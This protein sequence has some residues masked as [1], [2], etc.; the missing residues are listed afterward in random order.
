MWI[1]ALLEADVLAER[2]QTIAYS[3]IGP[4][5]THSIYRTGTIGRAKD[6]LERTARL[7]DQELQAKIN[8][9]AYVSVN[10]ALVTQSSA[11]IPVVPLMSHFCIK[12]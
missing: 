10:K 12:R 3:Y 8:G 7:L 9:N 11:A 2:A 5:I 4:D 6:D 1:R